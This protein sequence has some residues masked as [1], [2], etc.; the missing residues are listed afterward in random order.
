MKALKIF[1]QTSLFI[2]T[3]ILLVSCSGSKNT[4][5]PHTPSSSPQT[6]RTNPPVTQSTP[7]ELHG[8]WRITAMHML[9]VASR[10]STEIRADHGGMAFLDGQ[11]ASGGHSYWHVDVQSDWITFLRENEEEN[12]TYATEW[13]SDL[14]TLTVRST[15]E[16]SF[17]LERCD[18]DGNPRLCLTL[19]ENA[20]LNRVIVY[21]RPRL[22]HEEP[23]LIHEE[24]RLI[25]EEP[26]IPLV[27]AESEE[28]VAE[29][30]SSLFD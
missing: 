20:G 14:G 30:F 5:N 24:P 13:N 26:V 15:P 23:R 17:K 6:V 22:I 18:H 27:H 29:G 12:R 10:V 9:D 28:D 21:Y 19:Q 4:P 7:P 1:K 11:I 8:E 25:H 16:S 2:T 3:G